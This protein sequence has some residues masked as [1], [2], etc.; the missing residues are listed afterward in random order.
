MFYAKIEMVMQMDYEKIANFIQSNRRKMG[1]TQEELADL[2]PIGR[3]AV[4][5]WERAITIP[6]PLVLLKLSEIFNVSINEI[7]LGEKIN[8]HNKEELNKITLSL[9]NSINNSKKRIKILLISILIILFLFFSYYFFNSYKQVKIYTINTNNDYFKI[10]DALFIYT[11]NKSYFKIG[12]LHIN[13]NSVIMTN[14][15]IYYKDQDQKEHL[16]FSINGDEDIVYVDLNNKIFKKKNLKQILNNMY[17]RLIYNEVLEKSFKLYLEEDYINKELF[18]KVNNQ[19]IEFK[20]L[21]L[22]NKEYYINYI[23]TKLY[24]NKNNCFYQDQDFKFNY[25]N[26]YIELINKEEK[27]QYDVIN[28]KLLLEKNNKIKECSNNCSNYFYI[29]LEEALT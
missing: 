15:G 24:Q 13:N 10:E 5:K 14:V 26:N 17:I 20:D 9:F 3:G 28:N 21:F 25:L 8:N 11:R 18:N 29:K 7:L 6:D 16:L 19:N 22:M 12:K 23:K 27:W 1:L 4:S 2:I